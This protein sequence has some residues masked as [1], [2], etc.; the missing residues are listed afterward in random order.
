MT[1]AYWPVIYD[2]LSKK[3]IPWKRPLS[4]NVWTGKKYTGANLLTLQTAQQHNE[5]HESA[6]GAWGT[7]VQ[8][9]A[10]GGHVLED[11]QAYKV[12]SRGIMSQALYNSSHVRGAVQLPCQK[13][14]PNYDAANRI[15]TSA[16]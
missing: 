11:A 9:Q 6:P 12:K 1:K 4:F 14:R 2:G 13:Q 3:I 15:L 10:L 8:W 16:D 5:D 7:F